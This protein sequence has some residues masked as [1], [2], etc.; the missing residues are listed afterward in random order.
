MEYQDLVKEIIEAERG[1]QELARETRE[2]QEAREASLRAEAAAIRTAAMDRAK[3]KVEAARRDIDAAAA[4]DLE[5]W[6]GRLAAAMA[7]VE[8]ADRKYRQNWVE[9][10]FRMIVEEAP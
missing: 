8:S 1:A 9:T 7:T 2:Q 3:A 10:L 4:A 5:R 6:D